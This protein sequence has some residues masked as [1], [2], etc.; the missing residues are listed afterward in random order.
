MPA[1]GVT[2][3]KIKEVL[4][5]SF[6]RK[7]SQRKVAESLNLSNGVVSKYLRQFKIQGLTW[8]LPPE[9]TDLELSV[10]LRGQTEAPEAEKAVKSAEIDYLRVRQELARPHMTL[11]L[12]HSEMVDQE[13]L[14]LSYSQF[15]RRYRE[16][17]RCVKP[18]MRQ[19]HHAGD[20]AFVDYAGTTI[21]IL[22][23]AG[24]I[25]EAQVFIGVLGASNYTFAE[26]T[27]SQ[28]LVDWIGSHV[29]MFEYF[30]GV[31]GM[32]VPD[33]LK[34]GVKKACRYEPDLNPAYAQMIE[35][36]GC[37]CM[38]ARPY[39]P[40]DKAKVE[41]AVGIV[42][43]WII[44]RLRN[45]TFVGLS[46]LNQRIAELLT[47]LNNRP[48][49][50][51]PGCRRSVFLEVDQP[52]LKAL[53]S[54]RYEYREFK[55]ARVNVDY[56]IEVEGH[57]YSVPY[58]LMKEQI[59]VWYNRNIVECYHHG[60]LVA[61]H[62][63][64]TVKGRHTTNR[65]HMPE[66]HRAHGDWNAERFKIW[67]LSIG[68]ATES[69]ISIM[70][71]SRPHVEQAYRACMGIVSLSK[72]YGKARLESACSYALRHNL[73]AYRH[74]KAILESGLDLKKEISIETLPLPFQHDNLR[75]AHYYH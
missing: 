70:L 32:I 23:E 68:V 30:G 8:P 69:L 65:D 12:I 40:K 13:G 26:A 73:T 25:I 45:E 67:A 39:R 4:R 33:N 64:A 17:K 11:E 38:P 9:M 7:M 44:A 75:G 15:C 47:I 48:F 50:K 55:M 49:K 56:H 37:A 2:M 14:R 31:P 61:K 74:I 6:D 54:N 21:E 42:S 18:S 29:R 5:L 16:W 10:R 58:R 51:L 41:T 43:R 52:A 24:E 71:T 36:Y 34:S 60:S 46:A 57:Y 3:R 20:K 1:N 62:I 35:Y 72:K 66:S 19:N 22:N 63:R 28:K 27:L 59:E 53:P